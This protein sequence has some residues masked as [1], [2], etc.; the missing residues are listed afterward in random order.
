MIPKN[1]KQFGWLFI[2][3]SMFGCARWV[4]VG[5]SFESDSQ[6]YLVSLPEGWHRFNR[7][8]D[9]LR[10]TNDGFGLQEIRI[11]RLSPDKEFPNTKKKFVKGMQPQEIAGIVIDGLLADPQV[12]NLQIIEER[13]ATVGGES[14]FRLFYSY[15]THEGLTK[16]VIHYGL[17]TGDWYYGILFDAPARY[18]FDRDVATFE[19]LKDSFMFRGVPTS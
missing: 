2:L 4:T 3:L 13:P 9:V 7:D 14:G 16:K 6:R 15:R 12:N 19:K 8:T 10:I 5:G 18:Y 17:L 1:V 11:F